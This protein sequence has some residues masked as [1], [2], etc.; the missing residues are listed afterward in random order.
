MNEKTVLP[1]TNSS[2]L[3]GEAAKTVERFQDVDT[4]NIARAEL[5]YFQGKA[6]ECS[7][8]TE[9]YLM[10]PKVGHRLTACI[11]YV[12][13]NMTLGNVAKSQKGLEDIKEILR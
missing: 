8:I 6:Q 9:L 10:S 4:R 5:Y 3:P 11:L 1:L 12:Y 2:F 13:A 7:D